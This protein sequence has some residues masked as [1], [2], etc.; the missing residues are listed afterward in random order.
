MVRKIYNI[1]RMC[2]GEAI[3]ATEWRRAG[4]SVWSE[5]R[6]HMTKLNCNPIDGFLMGGVQLR[7]FGTDLVERAGNE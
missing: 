3:C 7:S 6:K 1:V 2:S 4:G 5:A